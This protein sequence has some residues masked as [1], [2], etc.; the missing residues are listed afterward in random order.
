MSI[1]LKLLCFPEFGR[2]LLGVEDEGI[3]LLD[4]PVAEALVRAL[5]EASADRRYAAGIDLCGSG[6][7]GL[8]LYSGGA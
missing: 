1:T 2:A 5:Q 6:S 3:A 7:G 8:G 4:T